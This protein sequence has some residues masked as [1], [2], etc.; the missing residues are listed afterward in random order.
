MHGTDSI[1]SFNPLFAHH[2]Q[3]GPRCLL[4]HV[5]MFEFF[6]VLA[7]RSPCNVFSQT[8]KNAE[9]ET[10][11]MHVC[12]CASMCVC[13]CLC[14]CVCVHAHASV[15]AGGMGGACVCVRACVHA[16]V[17]ACVCVCVCVSVCVCMCAHLA[18]YTY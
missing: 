14:V 18:S 17:R 6:A 2:T 4:L 13:A 15:H 10:V 16:C 12:V 8:N 3:C 5:K 7:K 1:F 9:R 11:C